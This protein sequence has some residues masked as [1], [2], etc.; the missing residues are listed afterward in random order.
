MTSVGATSGL[1]LS[2]ARPIPPRVPFEFGAVA[3]VRREVVD[4]RPRS[5]GPA[6]LNR[7]ALDLFAG[8]VERGT[9]S[10]AVPGR[11]QSVPGTWVFGVDRA[12]RGDH[13]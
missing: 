11:A 12:Q 9:P 3:R 1:L 5:T 7:L 6:G 10:Q 13:A 2:A 8:L 4:V